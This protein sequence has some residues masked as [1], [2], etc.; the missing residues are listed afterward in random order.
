M[1]KARLSSLVYK[2][3][4]IALDP[5]DPAFAMVELTRVV[6]EELLDESARRLA[7]PL[8]TF[9]ERIRA[10]GT[11]LAAEVASQGVQRVVEM[12]AE[13]RRTLATDTEQAQRRIA[14]HI[15]NMSEPLARQVAEAVRAAKTLPRAGIARTAWLLAGAA[16]G[17]ISCTCGFVGGQAA[18]A[19]GLVWLSVGR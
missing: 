12:L 19:Y 7:E 3:T 8:E 1:D 17:L 13:S 10:N 16:I 2:R 9:P 14:D 15:A 5:Q 18:A 11:S 4:G 6:L